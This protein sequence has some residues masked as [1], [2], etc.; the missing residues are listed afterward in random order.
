[1]PAAGGAGAVKVVPVV[2]VLLRTPATLDVHVTPSGVL[3]VLLSLVTAA[4]NVTVWAAVAPSGPSAVVAEAVTTTLM[5]A[6]LP[7]QP[8]R[9]K[10]A[11]IVITDRQTTALILRPESTKPFLKSNTDASR[12]VKTFRKLCIILKAFMS[13][14]IFRLT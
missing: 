5:G 13:I 7:P 9:V 12:N 6:E 4:D 1:L 8:D 2:E 10:A 11:I 3:P 14:G